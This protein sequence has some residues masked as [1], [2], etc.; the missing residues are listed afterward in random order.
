MWSTGKELYVIV[1]LCRVPCPSVGEVPL[2]RPALG[3]HRAAHP[4]RYRQRVLCAQDC[5]RFGCKWKSTLC[6]DKGHA[7]AVFSLQNSVLYAG[8]AV[9]ICAT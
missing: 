4:A 9:L 2:G 1:M 7:R 8:R 5:K 3:H 6:V